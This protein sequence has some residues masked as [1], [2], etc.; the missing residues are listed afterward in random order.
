MTTTT[1]TT[2]NPLPPQ[3]QL[4]LRHLEQ[5]GPLTDAKAR[6][7]YGI[8]RLG[9]RVWDLRRAGYEVQSRLIAVRTRHATARVAEYY[10]PA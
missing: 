10:L 1:P 2:T 6:N 5:E 3:C 4:V 7:L 9:A 8:A